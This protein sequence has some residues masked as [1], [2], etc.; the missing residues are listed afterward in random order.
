MQKALWC[1]LCAIL[2]VACVNNDNDSIGNPGNDSTIVVT[3]DLLIGEWVVDYAEDSPEGYSW[4]IIKFQESGIMYFSNYSDKKNIHHN[5][6]NG[7]YH[8]NGN[9]IATNCQLG[10]SDLYSTQNSDIKVISIS[11]YE[12]NAELVVH[13]SI[14]QHIANNHYKKVVGKIE[15]GH[16]DT[17]P[18]YQ[19]LIPTGTI[20]GYKSHNGYIVN[21][22]ERTG[23]MK[24]VWAGSTYVD[25]ITDEGTAVIQVNVNTILDYDYENCIGLHKD[26]IPKAFKFARIDSNTEGSHIYKDGY[27]PTVISTEGIWIYNYQTGYCP[28]LQS[29][30]GNWSSMEVCFN[31]STKKTEAISL[32]ARNDVWFTKYQMVDYLSNQYHLYKKEPEVV[33]DLSGTPTHKDATWKAYLNAPEFSSSTVGVTWDEN[34]SVLNF[35]AIQERLY[36]QISPKEYIPDYRNILGNATPCHFTS[37]NNYIVTVDENTGVLTGHDSGSTLIDI[38]TDNGTYS[39][40]VQVNAF[41][42][43]NYE[44]LLGGSQKD[45][46]KFYG[47]VPFYGNDNDWIFIYN[48]L[49]F[50]I[51]RREVGNWESMLLKMT[52]RDNGF[53][54]TVVL[55][56]KDDVWFTSEE[57]NKYLSER[58][59]AY[60]KDTIET[61][62]MYIN[63]EDISK[64]SAEIA[65]DMTKKVLT[66]RHLTHQEALPIFDYGRYMG[67]TQEGAKE[68]MQSEL[69]V[70]P[71]IDS[72][73][74]LSYSINN[75]TI[76]S[77][78]FRFDYEDKINEIVVRPANNIDKNVV[79]TE[80][81]DIYIL[82]YSNGDTYIFSDRINKIRA[83]YVVSSNFIQFKWK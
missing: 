48:S 80:L 55:T 36:L 39:I 45:V 56:A 24:G 26:S 46:N 76:A 12:L 60:A 5:Y 22:D 6:V 44:S 30:S 78:T 17:L 53:V 11:P 58:Y 64:A 14:N 75:E 62:R 29:Q 71:Y 40:R 15:I 41:L 61:V 16:K 43:E 34:N 35:I 50:D 3:S 70:R 19:R 67:L 20:T 21:A 51:Q 38:L 9:L 37:R 10:F 57:M 73:D 82:D 59:Y 23:V 4:E 1:F 2:F 69:G 27:Y 83:T 63:H 7:T 74:I 79:I 66:F 42:T 8:I 18:D 52:S 68:L 72:A 49:L 65:W 33:W 28:D 47:I 25:I 54:T 77:V 32:I 81:S 13:D 31:P